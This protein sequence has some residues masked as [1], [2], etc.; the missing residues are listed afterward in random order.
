MKKEK[1]SYKDPAG[2]VYKKD[3]VV[4][5][6]INKCYKENYD[7]FM[8]CGLY[9]KLVEKKYIVAHEEI[10]TDENV[11]NEL[12]KIIRPQKIDFVSYC[13]GF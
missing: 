5:R 4:Y 2:F 13:Y 11:D 6:Q 10:E 12:Y 9:K 7:F 3:G 8:Q 1:S